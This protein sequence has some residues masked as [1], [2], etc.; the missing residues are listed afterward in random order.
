MAV[1]ST[2]EDDV[3]R[4]PSMLSGSHAE[5]VDEEAAAPAME[6]EEE[7][8]EE[9][10]EEKESVPKDE[11][12]EPL[13]ASSDGPPVLKSPGAVASMEEP[14]GKG[15]EESALSPTSMLKKAPAAPEAPADQKQ[16]AAVQGGAPPAKK[17]A[18][19]K[20]TPNREINPKFKD[21]KETGKWGEI[22]T[23]ET[24]IAAAVA[25]VVII[26]VVVGVVVAVGNNDDAPAEAPVR[27][28]KAPTMAPTSILPDTE[29]ILAL[30]AIDVSDLTYLYQQDLSANIEDY[31][32]LM[33][34]P[35]A[36]P[37]ERAM[38]WLLY[39]DERD[40]TDEVGERWALAS[41]YYGWEGENWTSAENW[42]SSDSV[43]EWEHITCDLQTGDIREINLENNN[44]V[45]TIPNEMV[46][47]N[48]TQSIS[49]SG[50]ALTGPLPNEV[51]GSMPRLSILYLDNNQ[52]TGTIS[53]A[54]HDN[55]VL[56]SLFVQANNITGEWPRLFCPFSSSQPAAISNFGIDCDEIEC[57][58][59]GCC[60]EYN[61]YY[62]D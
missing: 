24:Y 48:S 14:V 33:E 38:S 3:P 6:E 17:T 10:E 40:L 59:V 2:D 47:L 8:D 23:K 50:N 53:L 49:L 4:D 26:G 42:L 29:L 54:I 62:D 28:T 57:V 18:T 39:D 20:K 15:K 13:D 5:E 37:Q 58:Q 56:N 7:E 16:E 44:L 51:F 34:D 45:G 12:E 61:C 31:E 43:C 25:L 21:L 46:M 36:S 52:L 55:G 19:K 35:S 30:I 27:P 32:G 11:E 9:K 60:T 1:K 41:L 22:S